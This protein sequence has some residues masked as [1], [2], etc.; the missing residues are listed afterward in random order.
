M[1]ESKC[2]KG[3]KQCD[4]SGNFMIGYETCFYLILDFLSKI[5]MCV[6]LL[7]QNFLEKNHLCQHIKPDTF[8]NGSE[9]HEK[10]FFYYP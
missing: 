3:L 1:K 7:F 9:L 8:G 2:V 6:L 4:P 10:T 5:I